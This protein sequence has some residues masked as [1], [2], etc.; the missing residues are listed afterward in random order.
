[1]RLNGGLNTSC[2][3]RRKRP[4]GSTRR[5]LVVLRRIFEWQNFYLLFGD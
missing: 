1:M 5:S 3:S 4:F 2:R